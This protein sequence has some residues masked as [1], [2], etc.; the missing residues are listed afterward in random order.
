VYRV[1]FSSAARPLECFS[2]IHDSPPNPRG[3]FAAVMTCSAADEACPVVLGAAERISLS[4]VDPGDLDGTA[5]E[6][7]AY[8]D[9]SR[10]LACEM[11]YSLSLVN[12]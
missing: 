11:L 4:Y 5:R 7:T 10:Q 2:K 6:R 9:C 1:W 3:G 12:L 8:D